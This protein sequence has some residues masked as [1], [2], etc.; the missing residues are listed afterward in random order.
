[1]EGIKNQ[2]EQNQVIELDDSS[3]NDENT[4]H[5]WSEKTTA[6]YVYMSNIFFA[7]IFH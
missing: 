5:L 2:E 6:Q 3:H 4:V 7:E 1:M